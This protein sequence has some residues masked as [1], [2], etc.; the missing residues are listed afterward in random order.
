MSEILNFLNDKKTKDGVEFVH[1]KGK[2]KS[3]IQRY[4]EAVEDIIEKQSKYDEFNKT[5]GDRNSFSKTDKDATFMKMKD[6]HMRNAQLKPGYNVQI[7]VESEYI[8]GTL[9]SSERSDQLTLIPFLK[10]LEENLDKK[11]LNI[12]ADA[13]YESEENYVFI[14]QNNQI[15]FI[16]PQNYE[17]MKKSNFK[18]DISK[19]ENMKYDEELDE[20][21]CYNNLKLRPVGHKTRTSKSG[22]KSE[23][24]IYECNDCSGCEHKSKCTRA[25][26][27]KKIQVSK[28]FAEKR[29]QSLNN[30]STPEGIVLRVN[31]SIQV[32]GAF[33]V[34]KEDY[35]FRRFYTRGKDNVKIEFMLLSLG[36]NINKLHN[37][38][39]N[40]RCCKSLHEVKVS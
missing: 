20:Y 16:K 40:D 36:Y 12:V 24:V 4:V 13:G 27:N 2:R 10:K 6:D 19:R 7:A 5:F 9:I 34:L 33:G 30:I 11:F 14:E 29:Q 25:A 31:R 39:Q 37:R 38:I 3:P 35:G 1:G 18:K 8:V 32:E 23:A 22:Y 26:G 17:T 15:S 21:T 28:V